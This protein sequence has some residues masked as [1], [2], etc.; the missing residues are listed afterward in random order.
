MKD[1][2]HWHFVDFIDRLSCGD[3]R[4]LR[5][6]MADDVTVTRLFKALRIICTQPHRDD[7][8]CSKIRTAISA[9]AIRRARRLSDA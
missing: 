8:A 6:V 2:E 5:E 4:A 7:E 3:D 1:F 9:C